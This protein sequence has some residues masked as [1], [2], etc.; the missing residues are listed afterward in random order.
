MARVITCDKCGIVIQAGTA[1]PAN[2]DGSRPAGALA[3]DFCPKHLLEYQELQAVLRDAEPTL[4]KA[5]ID[6]KWKTLKVSNEKSVLI[7]TVAL[8][9]GKT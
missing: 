8:K 3:H 9:G 6:G 2:P 5:W 1:M 4:L 7:S